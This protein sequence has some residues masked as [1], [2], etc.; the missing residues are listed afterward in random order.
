[1]AGNKFSAEW[2]KMHKTNS[3]PYSL[4]N[5]VAP[6]FP[7]ALLPPHINSSYCCIIVCTYVAELILCVSDDKTCVSNT[8]GVYKLGTSVPFCLYAFL[9]FF[10]QSEIGS[11]CAFIYTF[12]VKCQCGEWECMVWPII[13]LLVTHKKILFCFLK[14]DT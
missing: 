8:S 9:L 4:W 7:I 14:C 13:F 5:P 2:R 11:P 10:C 12:M 3:S 1:M 6:F